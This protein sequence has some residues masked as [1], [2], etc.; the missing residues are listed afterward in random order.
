MPERRVSRLGIPLRD[1]IERRSTAFSV[2]TEYGSCRTFLS[3]FHFNE[4][5]QH[6]LRLLEVLLA[7]LVTVPTDV[8]Y[9]VGLAVVELVA[10]AILHWL[11]F[12]VLV[13]VPRDLF[14]EGG[15][16]YACGSVIS[17]KVKV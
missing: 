13:M 12:H 4:H 17:L 9:D 15:D 6:M 5:L 10:L 2:W 1:L 7:V 16:W 3:V 11:N 14:I 8:F